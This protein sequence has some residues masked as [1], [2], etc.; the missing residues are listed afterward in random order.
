[1]AWRVEFLPAAGKAFEKLNRQPQRRIQQF[2]ETR[3][4]TD[5]DPHGLA[6]S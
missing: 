1:M 4:Q 6:G 2:I 3:L 5:G